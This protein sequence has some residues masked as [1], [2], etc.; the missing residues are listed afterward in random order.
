VWS[1]EK[2][3]GAGPRGHRSFA[4]IVRHSS[5]TCG[6]GPQPVEETV[7]V[8]QPRSAENGTSHVL[9]LQVQE[10]R[11]SDTVTVVMLHGNRMTNS[12]P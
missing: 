2:Q 8:G 11:G 9:P 5:W 3:R 7:T 4:W 12:N 10:Y 1:V 6:K